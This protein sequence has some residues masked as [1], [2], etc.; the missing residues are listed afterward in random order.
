[1]KRPRGKEN[2]LRRTPCRG[3][4]GPVPGNDSKKKNWSRNLRRE[5]CTAGRRT[6]PEQK[7][8]WAALGLYPPSTQCFPHYRNNRTRKSWLLSSC[9][10]ECSRL[11]LPGDHR[12]SPHGNSGEFRRFPS[13]RLKTREQNFSSRQDP[14]M[15]GFLRGGPAIPMFLGG[16]I[17]PKRQV[18]RVRTWG[19]RGQNTHAGRGGGNLLCHWC[20][21]R[22]GP[23]TPHG[24]TIT[25]DVVKGLPRL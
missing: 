14:S 4:P 23:T 19:Y 20:H 5:C 15:G 18:S 9:T 17:S 13:L 12:F 24:K 7:A 21:E 11:C 3:I 10:E 16:V 22:R 25:A 2:G 6:C 8:I 1:M